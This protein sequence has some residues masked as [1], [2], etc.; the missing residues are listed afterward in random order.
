MYLYDLFC[1][2]GIKT[3]KE[4]N[5]SKM[6]EIYFANKMKE[7]NKN[8]LNVTKKLKREENKKHT[9]KPEQPLNP[10]GARSHICPC[11]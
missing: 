7:W 3:I 9:Q 6:Y 8:F 5:K 11:F 4:N 1:Y 10:T 2:S